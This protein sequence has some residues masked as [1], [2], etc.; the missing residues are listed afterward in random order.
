VTGATNVG[1]RTSTGATPSAASGSTSYPSA[2]DKRFGSNARGKLRHLIC[3]WSLNGIF[4]AFTGEPFTVLSGVRTSNFSHVSRAVL[5]GPRPESTK[6]K[7]KAGVIGPV[8][9]TD[10]GVFGFPEPGDNGL[11]RNIFRGPGYWN[12]DLAAQKVFALAESVKLQFRAETFNTLNH[13]NFDTPV[14]ASTG[15][16]PDHEHAIRRNLLPGGRA[17]YDPEHH[18]DR[19]VRPRGAVRVEIDFLT[20]NASRYVGT[21]RVPTTKVPTVTPMP[22]M[23]GLPATMSGLRVM[24]FSFGR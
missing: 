4:T 5:T 18:P 16:K 13:P 20:Q 14:S 15:S 11:G 19:R 22:R 12:L 8:L 3:G 24:R 2:R 6:L 7:E 21:L 17:G 1:F 9:I 10:P 23:Q